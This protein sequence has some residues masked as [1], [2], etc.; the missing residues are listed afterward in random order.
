MVGLAPLAFGPFRLDLHNGELRSNGKVIK[1]RPKTFAV[2]AFLT[3]HAGR[4][5][6]REEIIANVWHGV[7]VQRENITAS[8]TELRRALGDSAQH[9]VY[10]ETVHG[11]GIRF[12]AEVVSTAARRRTAPPVRPSSAAP[13]IGRGELL[14]RIHSTFADVASGTMRIVVISGRAGVGKTRLLEEA[15]ARIGDRARVLEARA[16]EGLHHSALSLWAQMV[17]G[18]AETSS[19]AALRKALGA[20]A[21]DIAAV[22]PSLQQRLHTPPVPALEPEVARG[23][24]FDGITAFL[25]RVSSPKPLVVV[26]DDIHKASSMSLALLQSVLAGPD[27]NGLLILAAYREG[28]ETLNPALAALLQTVHRSAA[29]SLL[30]VPGLAEAETRDLVAELAGAKIPGEVVERVVRDT[31]GNPYFVLEILSSWRKSKSGYEVPA[32]VRRA[33]SD[34]LRLLSVDAQELARIGAVSGTIFDPATV[35]EVAGLELRTLWRSVSEC[36]AHDIL[37]QPHSSRK[38]LR[39]R[40]ELVRETLLGAIGELERADLHARIGAALERSAG[41]S[42]NRLIQ[43]AFH[44]SHAEAVGGTAKAIDYCIRAG[45]WA[46]AR[47]AHDEAFELLSR[48]RD[49]MAK[50]D[51]IAIEQRLQLLSL[52]AEAQARRGHFDEAEALAERLWT[53]GR[54]Q[55]LPLWQAKAAIAMLARSHLP[56]RPD[57]DKP[58][59]ALQSALAAI[60]DTPSFLRAQAAARLATA[61]LMKKDDDERIRRGRQAIAIAGQLEHPRQRAEILREVIPAFWDPTH[62]VERLALAEQMRE[63]AVAAGDRYL[64]CNALWWQSITSL[65][66]GRLRPLAKL[67]AMVLRAN[68]GV[69]FE[70]VERTMRRFDMSLALQH[71]QLDEAQRLMSEHSRFQRFSDPFYN[72]FEILFVEIALKRERGQLRTITPGLRLL[73]QQYPSLPLRFVVPFLLAEQGAVEEAATELDA[74]SLADLP[75]R[76]DAWGWLAIVAALGEAASAVGD[77]PRAEQIYGLLVPFAEH[78]IVAHES[79]TTFGSIGRVLGRLAAT[80]GDLARA[81]QHFEEVIATCEREG[82][83]AEL[84]RA[85]IDYADALASADRHSERSH[86]LRQQALQLS[87]QHNLE[88]IR[89]RA[90]SGQRTPPP[91]R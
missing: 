15:V 38:D 82:A 23:R 52:L 19:A 68:R 16:E 66:L 24:I 60:D 32:S 61:L 55:Q 10:I 3:E 57:V 76:N 51:S 36:M 11:R 12:L 45:E 65:A 27:I 33:I 25:T 29:A 69:E 30:T 70:I 83:I 1:L 84:T 2:L 53:I 67:R 46:L 81:A 77:R 78:W 18:F 63:A 21:A 47:Y 13:F 90:Q 39:F 20:A 89:R 54:V 6:S 26:F 17:R 79:A 22:I 7:A 28:G 75:P 91:R 74:L 87:R 34:R 80:S 48:A 86:Q 44:F 59:A 42:E 50:G 8:I 73:A 4:V 72:M 64:E 35:A 71:G 62:A 40:H 85:T 41:A 31:E 58:I 49:L 14:G 9:P 5:I 56:Y 37:V 88:A 43:I